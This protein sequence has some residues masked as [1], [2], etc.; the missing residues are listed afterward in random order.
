MTDSRLKNVAI[1][2]KQKGVATVESFC[3]GSSLKV[4]WFQCGGVESVG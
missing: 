4:Q 2:R 3:D 1:E